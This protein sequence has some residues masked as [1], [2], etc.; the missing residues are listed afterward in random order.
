MRIAQ[1][2]MESPHRFPCGTLLVWECPLCYLV[3]SSPSQACFHHSGGCACHIC[4]HLTRRP[5]SSFCL[6]SAAVMIPT[7]SNV[8]AEAATQTAQLHRYWHQGS[9][10]KGKMRGGMPATTKFR[11]FLPFSLF[12]FKHTRACHEENCISTSF[13]IS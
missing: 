7:A 6:C 10:P 9:Q 8:C 4:L 11:V 5:L 2:H 13:L 1:N 12:L 3:P